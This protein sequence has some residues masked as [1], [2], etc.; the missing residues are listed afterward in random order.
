MMNKRT[1]DYYLKTSSIKYR[2]ESCRPRTTSITKVI[3]NVK[4]K[5]GKIQEDPWE[6]CQGK[7]NPQQ[8]VW[9]KY[10]ELAYMYHPIR[11]KRDCEFLHLQLKR[12][13]PQVISC[14]T[15]S[16][17]VHLLTSSIVILLLSTTVPQ[18][19]CSECRNQL[20]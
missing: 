19:M 1:I 10:V 3:K 18:E 9:D 2:Q 5:P 15:I 17:T 14:W 12:N 13:S 7:K 8:V 16:E 11:S 4:E 6:T 20:Q